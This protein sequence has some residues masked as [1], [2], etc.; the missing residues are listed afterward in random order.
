MRRIVI[1]HQKQ[2]RLYSTKKKTGKRTNRWNK[3][4]LQEELSIRDKLSSVSVKFCGVCFEEDDGC[5]E[6]PCVE[7]IECTQCNMWVYL[8][9]TSIADESLCLCPTCANHGI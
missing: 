8:N 7:W 9:C 1:M 6:S 5:S 4:T 3:P 2:L